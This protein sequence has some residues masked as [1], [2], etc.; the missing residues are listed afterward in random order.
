[1]TTFE[2]CYPCF[3]IA[4]PG[5]VPCAPERTIKCVR[6]G[7]KCTHPNHRVAHILRVTGRAVLVT[8]LA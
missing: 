3:Q 4:R 6:C 5:E 7:Q 1:M 2:L 8:L